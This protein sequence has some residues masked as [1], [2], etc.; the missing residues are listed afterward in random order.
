M[1]LLRCTPSWRLFPPNSSS[2]TKRGR[3]SWRPRRRSKTRKRRSKAGLHLL[4]PTLTGGSKAQVHTTQGTVPAAAPVVKILGSFSHA[5]ANTEASQRNIELRAPLE[6][7]GAQSACRYLE[8]IRRSERLKR[9][10]RS[11]QKVRGVWRPVLYGLDRPHANSFKRKTHN[12]HG[13]YDYKI[14]HLEETP[15]S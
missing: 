1:C 12:G 9:S 14:L 4:Q 15:Y 13:I 8:V 3:R 2:S 10:L 6:I 7:S 5:A 11:L